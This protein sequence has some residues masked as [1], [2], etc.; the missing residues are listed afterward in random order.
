MI[1]FSSPW[2][3]KGNTAGLCKPHYAAYEGLWVSV[4]HREALVSHELFPWTFRKTSMSMYKKSSVTIPF[5]LPKRNLYRM[6][7]MTGKIRIL[8]FKL[9]RQ[10]RVRD[11]TFRHSVLK[12]VF[13]QS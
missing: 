10:S 1:S 11:E 5:E 7:Y 4:S 2:N 9:R 8:S 12:S 3:L 13:F 6:E